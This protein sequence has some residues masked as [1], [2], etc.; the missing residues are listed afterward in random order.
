MT[1][2]MISIINYDHENSEPYV[3]WKT[4]HRRL[5]TCYNITNKR[6]DKLCYTNKAANQSTEIS[7]NTVTKIE[8]NYHLV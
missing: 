3:W 2:G 6:S 4:S 8:Q 7:D 1:M 5:K